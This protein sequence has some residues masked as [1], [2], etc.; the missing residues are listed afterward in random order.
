MIFSITAAG[1]PFFERLRL[2]DV[3]FLLEQIG[4]D[5][6]LVHAE[7]R[8]RGDVHGQVA[9]EGLKLVG[10]RHEIGFAVH[11]DQNADAVARVDVRHHETFIGLA[12]RLLGRLRQSLDAKELD[13]LLDIA[14]A[15]FERLSCKSI[16]PAP[17]RSRSSFTT[18]APTALVSSDMSKCLFL[19]CNAAA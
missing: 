4:R 14:A 12:L 11:F 15:L 9:H 13:R 2:E 3:L 8:G 19:M 10:A 7:R 6:F 1:L 16:M 5:V 18:P 17:V